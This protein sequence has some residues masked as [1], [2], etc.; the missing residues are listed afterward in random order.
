VRALMGPAWEEM[1]LRRVLG[2]GGGM[3]IA[4]WLRLVWWLRMAGCRAIEA[5]AGV[6]GEATWLVT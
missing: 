3:I 5:L 1:V 4:W 2:N 6:R